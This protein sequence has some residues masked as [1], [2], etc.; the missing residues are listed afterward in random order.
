LQWRGPFLLTYALDQQLA[1]LLATT[2]GDA[3]LTPGEFAVYSVLHGSG[4]TT[5]SEL[6]ADLGLGRSTMSNWLRR[7]EARGHL[8]RQRNPADGRSQLVQLTA[9]GARL[10]EQCFPAFSTAIETFREALEIDEQ[11]LLEVLEAMSAALAVA[12]EKL[13]DGGQRRPAS[14]S[15]R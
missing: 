1:E 13:R 4:P 7:M 14:L 10:T 8:R 9:Q 5:P 6:A 3:P 11:A 12:V 2:F 15:A